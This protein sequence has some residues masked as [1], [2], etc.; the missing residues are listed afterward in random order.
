MRILLI[1]DDA[2]VASAIAKNLRAEGHAVDIA[3]NGEDG[4]ELA[5]INKNDVIILDIMLPGQ[6]GLTTCKNL[7]HDKINTP[8]L[9]LTALGDVSD[10]V[11][12][13]NCG[14]DDYLAKPFHFDEL[15]ARIRALGRRKDGERS[16]VLEKFGV[17]LDTATH[18]AWREGQEIPLSAKE[19]ALLEL[20]MTRPGR[21]VTRE[22][23]SEKLWD[24]NFEPQ[25]NIIESFVRFLRQKIDKD[26]DIPLIHTMRGSGYLFSD[27]GPEKS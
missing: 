10:R 5:R 14:A 2:K 9:M 13:L 15:H 1:E 6:D 16:P 8:I 17:K 22:A 25:S 27:N 23:I 7:R 18:K 11:K 24:M 12:G 3:K 26:F 20:F 21:I 19:F 4:E